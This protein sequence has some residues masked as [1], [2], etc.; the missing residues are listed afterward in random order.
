MN[1]VYMPNGDTG[2]KGLSRE[3]FARAWA[4]GCPEEQGRMLYDL[5]SGAYEAK[6]EIKKLKKQLAVMWGGIAVVAVIGGPILLS[7][8]N[9]I[10]N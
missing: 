5:V 6:N 4:T 10:G 9:V 1:E 7:A 3:D 8:L 2:D